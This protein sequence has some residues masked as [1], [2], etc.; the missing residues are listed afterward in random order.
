MK[1]ALL[2]L[3]IVFSSASLAESHGMALSYHD[4]IEVK[5]TVLNEKI[6]INNLIKLQ[7]K[8]D[9]EGK[10]MIAGKYEIKSKKK[11]S[12]LDG[13]RSKLEG[14]QNLMRL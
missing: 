3:S 5:K 7:H 8:L 2:V 10:R 6:L 13:L 14:C 4:S 1:I 12:Y 9:F 11:S